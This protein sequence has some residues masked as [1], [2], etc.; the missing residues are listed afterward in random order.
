MAEAQAGPR[1]QSALHSEAAPP[2]YAV[3]TQ[4]GVRKA[5]GQA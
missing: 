5:E 4:N 3:A 1:A 2:A